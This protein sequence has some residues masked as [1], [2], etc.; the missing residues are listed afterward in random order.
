MSVTASVRERIHW[1]MALRCSKSGILGSC[2][3]NSLSEAYVV[4]KLKMFHSVASVSRN[5]ASMAPSP[6]LVDVH[7]EPCENIHQRSGSAPR[8]LSTSHGSMTLPS[9]LL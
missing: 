6:A 8:V 7:G 1:S 5:D 4:K 2:G 3:S 9:D